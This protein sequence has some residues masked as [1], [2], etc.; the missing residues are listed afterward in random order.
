MNYNVNERLTENF[1][2]SEAI[3]WPKHQTM[4][5]GD[6][7]K[8]RELA[9]KALRPYEY[10]RIKMIAQHLQKIRDTVNGQYPEMGG[11]IGLRCLSWLRAEEW[12]LYRRRSGKSRHVHGDAVDFI[13]TN[14][15]N[16]TNEVMDWI[17][18]QIINHNGG[19][20]RLKRNGIYSFIHIDLGDRRRW[21]Y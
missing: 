16:R 2:L 9:L 4:N 8:A 19:L 11:K 20:A 14:C 12:E 7:G 10:G 13:V 1:T 18:R 5:P 17:Y 21:E 3:D 6:R 15:G